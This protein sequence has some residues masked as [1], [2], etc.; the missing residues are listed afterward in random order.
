MYDLLP[1]IV[2]SAKFS[3]FILDLTNHCRFAGMMCE[4]SNQ[5]LTREQDWDH[6]FSISNA[7]QGIQIFLSLANILQSVD[8]E[9]I[10]FP[11]MKWH[12]TDVSTK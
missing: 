7:I 11:Y 12:T 3:H 8:T 4:R 9:V 6:L 2:S 10:I 1:S 5:P